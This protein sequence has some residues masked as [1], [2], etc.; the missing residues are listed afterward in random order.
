MTSLASL[1]L[2]MH[3]GS[4]PAPAP[5]AVPGTSADLI[6]EQ[7]EWRA[8][9]LAG[10]TRPEG[11]LS[12]VGLHWLEPG[13]HP[14]GTDP[15]AAIELAIGPKQLGTLSIEPDA[16]A[17]AKVHLALAP[18]VAARFEQAAVD[19]TADGRV[20]ATLQSDANGQTPSRV[21][22][23][24]ASFTLI[25]RSGRLALRV[26]DPEAT[27]RTGFGGLD[28]F[29]IDAQWRIEAKL[30]RYAEPKLIDIATIVG[31]IEPTP[32]IGQAVF[33]HEGREYRLELL[34]DSPGA[35]SWFVIFG[36]RSNGRETYGMARFLYAKPLDGERVLVD[37]N[38]AYNPPC[39]FTPYATCPMPPDGNRL[40]FA[41]RA[42]EKKYAG[43]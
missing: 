23:G 19:I 20:S 41:V 11:W 13:S 8:R 27:T 39:A 36:D 35:S 26:R 1:V 18:G 5:E 29:P 14:I 22:L 24:S 7:A 6:A 3:L 25:D 38:Q 40:D 12:L 37:F 34:E 10:L 15:G 17:S 2:A 16:E 43:P 42:G 31:G 30:A 4:T 28:Y 32:S 21:Q 9:R 33:E